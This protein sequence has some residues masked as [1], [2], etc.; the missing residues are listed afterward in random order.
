[1]MPV[2]W[3]GAFAAIGISALWG[4]N[5]VAIKVALQGIQPMMMAGLTF[6][7]GALS[8]LLWARLY[9]IPILPDRE[10]ILNHLING[11]LFTIQVALFY[12]GAHLTSASHTVILTNTN[13]F[14]VALLSHF[15]ILGDRLTLFKMFG[16]ILAFFGVASLFFDQPS[17]RSE[18]SLSG[19]LVILLSALF[20]A[21]R[22]TYVKQMVE[23]VEPSKVVVWQMLIGVPI[24][25][26]LAF[27]FE[28]MKINVL[29][30]KILFALLYQGIVVAGFT[31]VASTLLLKRYSPTAL[32]VF[33]FTVPIAGVILSHWILGEAFTQYILVSM[34][35]VALGI[36]MVHAK[37]RVLVD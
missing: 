19:N 3:K 9:S 17:L 34:I 25:F 37:E 35:L 20:L 13:I 30:V 5:I 31:F 11:L 4:G 26:F 7:L 6:F 29:S 33:F 1:M 2:S 18:A 10:E 28:E 16:L 23:R 22:I 8:I 36:W 27:F 24:F 14:F 21:V 32:S 15:F 12:W